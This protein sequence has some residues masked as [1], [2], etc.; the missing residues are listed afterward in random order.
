MKPHAEFGTIT[1]KCTICGVNLWSNLNK[2]PA[3]MPCNIK[4]CPFEDAKDQNPEINIENLVS[5]I[6]NATGQIE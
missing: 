3:Y 5:L 1:G 4:M 6:G 2:R